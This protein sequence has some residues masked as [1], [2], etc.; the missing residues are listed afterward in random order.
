VGAAVHRIRPCLGCRPL[1]DRRLG[2]REDGPDEI[3]RSP[4]RFL[5]VVHTGHRFSTRGTQLLTEPDGFSTPASRFGFTI[6]S[7][8]PTFRKISMHGREDAF[9]MLDGY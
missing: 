8:G 9:K 6:A 2:A 7:I 1:G 3:V 4:I 5:D